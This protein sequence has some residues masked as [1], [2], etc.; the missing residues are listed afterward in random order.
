MDFVK[1]LRSLEEFL[2]EA[3]TWVVLYPRTLWRVAIG[4]VG[5][6]RYAS[7][8]LAEPA[9]RQFAEALSPP[10]TLMLTLAVSHGLEL[11]SG[12]PIDAAPGL[13]ATLMSTEQNLLITR[14]VA[15]SIFPLVYSALALKR[16]GLPL[17][18]NSLRAPFFAQCYA[19]AVYALMLGTAVI[20]VRLDGSA[21]KLAGGV[22]MLATVTW[23]IVTEARWFQGQLGIG[24]AAAG[25]IAAWGFLK[26]SVIVVAIAV[27][28]ALIR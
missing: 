23:Y 24:P 20:L 28:L 14:A 26:A 7:T 27:A 13:M 4:P 6:M 19:A 10:L 17:D 15:Y 25:L 11:S 1:I 5:M 2:Y 16:L 8:Q 9:E 18:R 22:L 12:L 3:M 21:P